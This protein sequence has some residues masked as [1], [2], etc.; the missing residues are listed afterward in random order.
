MGRLIG[1]TVL[2][3]LLTSLPVAA[4][5]ADVPLVEAVKAGDVAG[6]RALIEQGVDV[7]AAEVDGTTPL[8]WAANGQDT[9]IA[10]LLLAAGAATVGRNVVAASDRSRSPAS[11][12][13]PP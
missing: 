13:T 8:H 10:R 11:T 4:A 9:E 7:N 2:G 6:V 3:L 5:P 1:V 12:A